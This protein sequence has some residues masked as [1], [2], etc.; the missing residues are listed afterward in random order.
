VNTACTAGGASC[1]GNAQCLT[2]GF[3]GCMP[4]DLDCTCQEIF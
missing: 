3:A 1:C 2:S 4:G